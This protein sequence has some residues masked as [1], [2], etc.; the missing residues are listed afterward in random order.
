MM[1]FLKLISIVLC[2]SLV[3][4]LAGCNEEGNDAAR[5]S[6]Q[7]PLRIGYM[8]CDSRELS[9]ARFAPLTA[10]LSEKLGRPV[11]MVLANTFEFED[12]AKDKKVDL[13]HVNSIVALILQERFNLKLLAV[14]KR[15]RNGHKSTGTIISRKGSGIKTIQDMKGKSMIFGPAL[16]PF[17]Y[18]A[19]YA[20]MLEAGFDPETDLSFY[21]IPPG[22]AKHEK[23]IYGVYFG[24]YDVGA[25]P[26]IDYDLMINDHR[27]T[28]NDFNIIAESVPMP[29]CTIGALPHVPE[30]VQKQVLDILLN[31]K[32]DETVL[33]EGEVLNVLKRMLTDGF[34]KAE[35]SEY[36]IIREKLKLCNM[37]PYRKN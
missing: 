31:L 35:D 23:V 27:I 9:K 30:D 16:A 37:A 1:N 14:D 32:K 12:L 28:K 13:V 25:A 20:M 19:Q 29:Y 33:V 34:V 18:M 10:Y 6:S 22:A 5:I 36:D 2:A 17:G 15:G 11:E 24:K 7:P 3:F 26:R 8:I 21:A 4:C